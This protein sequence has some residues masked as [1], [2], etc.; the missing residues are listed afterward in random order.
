MSRLDAPIILFCSERSGS[1]MI[2]KIFDAHPQVCAPGDSHLF[3]VMSECAC[4]YVPGSEALRS[5]VLDL[6]DAKVCQW[7]IDAWTNDERAALLSDLT[8]ASEMAAAI[9]AAEASASG[10]PHLMTKENSS[11]RYL[12]MLMAQSTRPRIL[13]MTRDPRDMAVSWKNGPVMRGGVLRA[14]ERWLYDQ[15]GFIETISQLGAETKIATLR[16]EDVLNDPEGHLRRV[17]RELDLSF[18]ED[19][20]TFSERSSGAR[21]D[22]ERSLMWSNLAKPILR[23]NMEKFRHELDDAQI[24]YIEASTAPLMNALGYATARTNLPEFGGFDTLADL[25]AYLAQT[26]PLDKAAYHSLPCD[27]RARFEHWSRLVAR[28]RAHPPL[29]PESHAQERS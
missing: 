2:A 29:Q 7:S 20:L 28:M 3:D 27:E 8:R 24:A 6:F 15:Q 25:R 17:C 26:E 23:N 4:R 21:I 13:F 19:M 5:A 11:F 16:Y 9:Y 18:S 14:T 1:N 10:K 12:P 22:A